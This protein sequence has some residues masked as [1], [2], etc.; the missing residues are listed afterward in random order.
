MKS[1]FI[2]L[3]TFLFL[4]APV[5]L[6]AQGIFEAFGFP[7]TV[8]ATG[9]T[10]VAGG[11]MVSLRLGTTTA[12]TLV[13][14][15]SPL[16]ITNTNATDIRVTATGIGVGAVDLT[17][18]EKGLVRIPVLAGATSGSIRIDGIRVSV[19]G[20]GITSLNARLSWENS[21]NIFSSS[22]PS[23][24]VINAVQSGLAADPVT[25]RFV[26]FNGQI[27]DNTST[28][29]LREGYG[30]AFSNSTDFGQTVATRIRIR[31]SDFPTNLQ[32][33]FPATVTAAESAATLTTVQG[34]AVTLPKGNGSTEVTYA[35]AGAAG[36]NEILESFKIPFTVALT[37]IPSITQPT[38]ELSL[39]PIG[40]A[41]PDSTFPST[42]VPRYA[43]E[44]IV[45]QEG[46]S[47]IITKVL[48]W[49]GANPSL[50]NRVTIFNA[51][52]NS[53]NLT[54]DALNSSG[55]PVS[56]DGITNPVKTSLSANQSL[57][58]TVSELFG[59]A[60]GVSSIRIQS[61]NADVLAS[62]QVSGA[63]RAES[64][65]FLTRSMAGFFVPVVN[66][67][68][69]LNLM[70]P[71]SSATTG[72][73][74]LRTEEGRLVSTQ[75]VQLAALASTSVSL[76]SVFN[77]PASGYVFASFSIPVIAFESFGDNNALN[78]LG[79]QPGASVGSLYIP[80]FAVGN[81]FET[82]VN[83]INTSDE[84]VTLKAQLFD[85]AGSPGT[86][87]SIIMP[88]NEQL[89]RLLQRIFS[90]VPATGYVRFEVPQLFKGFFSFYPVITGHARIRSS[91]GGSTVV[92]LSA[93]AL[94]D[95]LIL[96]SGTAAGEFE[97]V[98]LVN[99]N[100]VPVIVTLQAVNSSGT[101][102]S[103]V[104]LTLNPGQLISQLTTQLFSGEIP[105][106]SVIRVTSTAP[107]VATA[108]TGSNGL[109]VLRSL[110]VLR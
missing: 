48:Y 102:L 110:P 52:S 67:N 47:R 107:I 3:L 56:G 98:A 2:G 92:P 25:D 93:Y 71:N 29:A 19:A 15:V 16:R 99:P 32:M 28:I 82:D 14:D 69:Q 77:N 63:G 26:I 100:S 86:S 24:A 75:S 66:E 33:V 85:S 97:G 51:S 36:S 27:F 78:M 96:E 34:T 58:R 59:S 21:L 5:R 10:E 1:K 46:S 61:T 39:A 76:G 57:V 83:L 45:V 50:A 65:P 18:A 53:A 90:Q 22:A 106:Q 72:T 37:G 60:N 40:A 103:T 6:S 74:T 70:N 101:V 23:V 80:F 11:V 30:A 73:L 89:A 17:D 109:D 9:H 81:G 84:T 95:S 91:Q 35:F 44:N 108:I 68:A 54:I 4:V 104:A 20:T 62:V 13:I 31:V 55:Q 43:E 12:G 94:R 42:D 105:V 87:V 41:V 7:K 79:I 49:T 38:I 88:P 8:T 64:V